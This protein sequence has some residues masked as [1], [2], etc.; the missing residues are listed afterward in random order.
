[1]RKTAGGWPVK[2]QR[3]KV[4]SGAFSF[5]QEYLT[6]KKGSELFYLSYYQDVRS[7]FARNIA[8]F[9]KQMKQNTHI[10]TC[11]ITR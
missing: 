7:L 5:L 6:G 9:H 4:P 11:Q 8:F 1:M 10:N 2:G 3:E